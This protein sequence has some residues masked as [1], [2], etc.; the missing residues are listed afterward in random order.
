M[1]ARAVGVEATRER[2]L[3]AAREAFMTFWYDDVTLRSVASEAEVALQT[4]VNHFGTK[5]A[6][7]A[8]TVERIDESIRAVRGTAEPG[9]IAGA[10]ETLVADYEE[11]GDFTLRLLAIENRVPA[12]K[13]GLEVGR[14]AHEGWVEHVFAG[15]LAGLRG[16]TRKRRLAQLVVATD[17]FTWKLLRRDKR[18]SPEETIV[19][20]RELVE[21]LH[22]QSGGSR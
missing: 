2:I 21:A 8:A 4:V 3:E 12:V 6:L 15:A 10:V 19:A 14:R 18:L 16:A 9:D 7:Y 20:I 11:T 17:V 22:N 13:P 1:S 5:E